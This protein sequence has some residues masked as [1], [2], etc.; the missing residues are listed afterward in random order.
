MTALGLA[1][2]YYI[3]LG[4]KLWKVLND[5]FSLTFSHSYRCTMSAILRD[6]RDLSHGGSQLE[7]ALPW[8]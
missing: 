8:L 2:Y 5:S 6:I 1:C 3:F 7:G 4:R